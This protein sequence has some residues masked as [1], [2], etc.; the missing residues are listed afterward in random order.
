M[1]LLPKPPVPVPV[2]ARSYGLH[3]Q[4]PALKSREHSLSIPCLPRVP[5]GLLAA[6]AAKEEQH[7]DQLRQRQPRTA[8]RDSVLASNVALDLDRATPADR[9]PYK[10]ANVGRRANIPNSL[11][12]LL[13]S[14]PP[15]PEPEEAPLPDEPDTDAQ[16]AE[17]PLELPEGAPP[18]PLL[19]G[20]ERVALLRRSPLFSSL[21]E[22]S[23]QQL[24]SVAVEKE[25]PRYQTLRPSQSVLVNVYGELAVQQGT[26]IPLTAEMPPELLTTAPDALSASAATYAPEGLQ[27]QPSTMLQRDSNPSLSPCSRGTPTP[28]FFRERSTPALAPAAPLNAVL[29]CL[30][31]D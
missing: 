11:R 16:A 19:R 22:L 31:Y 9:L 6:T 5:S 28:A 20:R 8:P 13:D 26:Y 12:A 3:N 24:A 30:S 7:L 18:L 14:G 25:V 15:M 29:S 27:P 23:L 2:P 10:L 1:V 21:P 4:Q 17:V